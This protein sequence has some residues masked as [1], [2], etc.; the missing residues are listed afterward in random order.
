VFDYWADRNLAPVAAALGLPGRLAL[1]EFEK[2][3]PT[4][5]GGTPPNLDLALTADSGQVVGVESKFSEW[6]APKPAGKELFKEKYFPKGTDEVGRWAG[7]ALPECQALAV[8]LQTG[9]T[10]FRYLD[11]AQLLKHVLGMAS[12]S[13]EHFSLYYL[14][15]DVPGGE[16]EVHA[17]EVTQFEERVGAEVGFKSATYQEVYCRFVE[18][19]KAEHQAYLEYLRGRYFEAML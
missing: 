2:Q 4:G 17:R 3:F 1:L 19:A 7:L 10:T 9:R 8:D 18:F 14:Y 5:L 15:F 11:A 16:S 6:L 12:N 13:R